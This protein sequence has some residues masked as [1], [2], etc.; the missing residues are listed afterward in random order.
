VPASIG[1]TVWKDDDGDGIQDPNEPPVEG[2]RVRLLDK[3]ENTLEST[4]TDADGRYEF[5]GLDPNQS[6]QLKFELPEALNLMF[7]DSSQG[8]DD[9]ADSDVAPSADNP[10]FGLTK[11]FITL[12][13]G[14]NDDTIDAGVQNMP[15]TIGDRA[16][17]DENNND[18]QD[19]GES[20]LPDATITLWTD[21]TGD[22]QPDTVLGETITDE[23]GL[24]RF[25]GLNLKQG[26]GKM[27]G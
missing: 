6:Y 24:Y 11:D 20:D 21:T 2:I 5:D 12:D 7:T 9:A 8:G 19:P 23:E 3:E 27:E 1:D 4:F 25:E 14:E 22:G 15:A 13:P 17:L 16:W 10:N 26:D 18:I